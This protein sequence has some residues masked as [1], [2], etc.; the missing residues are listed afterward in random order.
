MELEFHTMY[1][2][3]VVVAVDFTNKKVP[4]NVSMTNQ[5]DKDS[6]DI[7]KIVARFDRT[8]NILDLVSGEMRKPVW[9]DFSS[10]GDYHSMMGAVTRAQQMFDVLRSDIRKR[11][12]NDPAK[13]IA[14]LDDPANDA[15]ALELGLKDRNNALVALADDGVT[16]ITPVAREALDKAAAAKAAAAGAVPGTVTPKE[17]SN[18]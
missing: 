14:F 2:P 9:G 1:S 11:F 12:D 18:G 5:A 16:K 13:L 10:I 17:S 6:S 3:R 7:N 8:Q 15:E 4:G